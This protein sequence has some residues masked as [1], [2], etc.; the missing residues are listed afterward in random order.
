[1]HFSFLELGQVK[2]RALPHKVEQVKFHQLQD[3][4][5]VLQAQP[6]MD[7]ALVLAIS[8]SLEHMHN[9][10]RVLDKPEKVL[11][12]EEQLWGKHPLV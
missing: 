6:K 1:M 4:Q 8:M 7:K 10:E 5:R 11:D 12:R 2:P 3:H 9:Q